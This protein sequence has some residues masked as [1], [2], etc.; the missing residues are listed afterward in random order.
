MK[1]FI[2]LSF[3]FCSVNLSFASLSPLVNPC[4]K[5]FSAS[6][7]KKYFSDQ[8]NKV[9][10]SVWRISANIEATGFF[11]SPNQFVTSFHVITH[12]LEESNLKE[13]L[14]IQE[15]SVKLKIKRI[16][17]LSA[18]HDLAVLEIESEVSHYL[19]LKNV[20]IKS[21]DI[22][23]DDSFFISS[24]LNKK[25]RMLFKTGNLSGNKDIINFTVDHDS[26]VGASG[27]PVLNNKGEVI[28][29]VSQANI[30][31]LY[32][33]TID[34]LLSLL[35]EEVDRNYIY[36]RSY[37]KREIK[38]LK[39]LATEGNP[40]A[41]YRLGYIYTEG[42]LFI[43]NSSPN[44]VYLDSNFREGFRWLKKAA[45]QGHDRA[46]ESLSLVYFVRLRRDRL[47]RLENAFYWAIQAA[48][49]GRA[50]AQHMLATFYYAQGNHL[51]KAL[52]WFKKA[53]EQGF[54]E[55]QYNVGKIYHSMN[56]KQKGD[57]WF[58]KAAEQGH[59]EAMLLLVVSKSNLLSE[60]ESI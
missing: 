15:N 52:Y 19:P 12:L 39:K 58:K 53:A 54:V 42:I 50:P 59:R 36:P 11:I 20:D 6:S 1:I 43:N 5:V 34:K 60:E 18:I 44:N 25:S 27:S 30:N 16:Q 10:N 7:Q 2:L 40:E 51:K 9:K 14:I 46:E 41:Q 48:K 32:A 8:I 35:K 23:S 17:M 13:V 31:M 38:N 56:Q 24:Y 49:K 37:V 45:E 4:E 57:Y 28:G 26:L 29:I 3:F 33:V 22:K 21:V 47:K 55:S